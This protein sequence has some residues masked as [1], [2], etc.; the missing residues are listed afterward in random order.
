MRS[1]VT[2]VMYM[3]KWLPR[4]HDVTGSMLRMTYMLFTL[5][6]VLLPTPLGLVTIATTLLAG[7]GGQ[8]ADLTPD[9]RMTTYEGKIST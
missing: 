4:H 2:M 1:S 3:Y 5:L 6:T 7:S 8:D 9:P